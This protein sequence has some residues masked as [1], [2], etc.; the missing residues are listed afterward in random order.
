[1]NFVEI[2]KILKV[3]MR[4]YRQELPQIVVCV[5]TGLNSAQGQVGKVSFKN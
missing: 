1:M 2:V 3:Q 5:F 4:N